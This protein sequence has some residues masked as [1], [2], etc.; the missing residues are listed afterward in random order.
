MGRLFTSL[1]NFSAKGL[2]V[3]HFVQIGQMMSWHILLEV[4]H[5]VPQ[6]GIYMLSLS[7]DPLKF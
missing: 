4:V 5:L 2:L 3:I 6:L 7:F 1:E